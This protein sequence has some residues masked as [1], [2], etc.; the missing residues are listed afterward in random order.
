MSSEQYHTAVRV[1]G[2]IE[3]VSS[4]DSVTSC[5]R[6]W[7]VGSLLYLI[8]TLPYSNGTLFRCRALHTLYSVFAGLVSAK[9]DGIIVWIALYRAAFPYVGQPIMLL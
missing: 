6:P 1:L 8:A 5:W 7:S 4:I 3:C 2:S 9:L